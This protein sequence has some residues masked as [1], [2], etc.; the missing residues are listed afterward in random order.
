MN[1]TLLML[2]M[3]GAIGV[4]AGASREYRDPSGFTVQL[5][6]GWQVRTFDRGVVTINGASPGKYVL[7]MPIL[8]RTMDCATSLQKNLTS[9]WAAYPGASDLQIERGQRGATARFF[10]QQKQNRGVLLCAE[11]GS[12]SGMMYGISGP[13]AEFAR[14]QPVMVAM[15]KSFK[16]GGGG[17]SS[18]SGGSGAA[19]PIPRMVKWREP[20][21]GAYVMPIPE[22]WQPQGGIQRISNT[23]VRGGLRVWSPD[24][25]MLVQFNDVRLDKILV[26]GRQQMPQAQMGTGWRIGPHQSGTQMAEWYLRQ[27]WTQELGLSDLEVTGRQDRSDLNQRADAVP[28]SM[29][30]RGFQ[31]LF[32]EVGFRAMRNGRP[33][34]GRLL[35]MTRM[36]WSP[37]PDLAGGSYTTE[38]KGFLGPVGSVPTLARIGSYMEGNCEYNYQWIA[39]NRQAASQDVQA[40]LNQMRASAQMQQQAFWDRMAASDQRREAVNDILGGRVRL[41]DGQGN[42]YE[43]KAGSNYYFYDV[44][45]GR[46]AGNPN[47]AVVG[48]DVYPAPLVD[49]RPLEVIR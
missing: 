4:A 45:A 24:Q 32:G 2:G 37:V 35:G 34:E 15:L 33:V 40:T 13:A 49:L 29:G 16:Y 19:I 7:I 46:T 27:F 11:T 43:A 8:G 21:E 20:N 39:A 9:G 30:V 3:C 36:L 26:M 25:T 31:H 1:R 10:F 14:D 22:G 5:A 23:D 12:R 6:D 42:Q 48:A 47:Q 17:T 28:A 38:I 18:G 41:N 44:Q